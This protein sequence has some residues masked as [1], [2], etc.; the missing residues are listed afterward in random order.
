MFSV[1][2]SLIDN[3]KDKPSGVGLIYNGAYLIPF[4]YRL[5]ADSELYKIMSTNPNDK[6]AMKEQAKAEVEAME[7]TAPQTPARP[8]SAMPAEPA[9]VM[10]ERPVAPQ[11][12]APQVS[13]EPVKPQ[14][15]SGSASFDD[16]FG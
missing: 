5:S 2:D 15:S 9:P 13:P 8:S 12:E 6:K 1:S 11:A 16:F 3:I 7:Q 14:E 10:P 4:N